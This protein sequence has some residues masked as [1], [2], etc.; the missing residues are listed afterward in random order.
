MSESILVAGAGGFI[1]GH[2]VGK[3][4][5]DG[6]RVRAVDR[7]PQRQW[8]QTHLAAEN[9]TLNLEEKE[10]VSHRRQRL[11]SSVQFRRR[12]GR[13]GIY[14]TQ[15]GPVYAQRLDQHAH[16]NGGSRMRQRSASFIPHQRV[17][18]PASSSSV[19]IFQA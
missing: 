19:P 7:K 1:G 10:A 16:A 8:Y 2:L 17:S 13:D 18:T 3:L 15:Q 9:L 4:L 5:Q 11:R 12:H 14:R 6:H